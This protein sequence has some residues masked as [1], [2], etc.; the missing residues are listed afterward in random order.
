MPLLRDRIEEASVP[1]LRRFLQHGKVRAWNAKELKARGL[2]GTKAALLRQQILMGSLSVWIHP[3]GAQERDAH[4]SEEKEEEEGEEEQAPPQETPLQETQPEDADAMHH[5]ELDPM[6]DDAANAEE[7]EDFDAVLELPPL[8]VPMT[9]EQYARK[10]PIAGRVG[11]HVVLCDSLQQ[12]MFDEAKPCQLAVVA[13][14]ALIAGA[15]H[16]NHM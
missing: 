5:A 4:A 16:D 7:S 2:K 3:A 13:L 11:A 9:D 15:S 6:D 1:Q 8:G 12:K 10:I 14:Y